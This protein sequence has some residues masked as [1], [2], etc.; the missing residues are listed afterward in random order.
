MG[1]PVLDDLKDAKLEEVPERKGL[2]RVLWIIIGIFMLS[3]IVVYFLPGDVTHVLGGK[4]ES[5]KIEGLEV[6]YDNGKV[7]FSEE[8]YEELKT[9]YLENQETEIKVCLNGEKKG[10]DYFVEELYIPETVFATVYSVVSEGCG[11]ALISLH[12]HPERHCLFSEQDLKSE[13]MIGL[14]CEIDRFSFHESS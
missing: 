10:N 14:M 11:D 5:S 9:L 4:L 6:R 7:V 8:V 1:D 3:I 2:K 12:T 13:G